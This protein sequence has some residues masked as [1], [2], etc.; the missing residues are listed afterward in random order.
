MTQ[1]DWSKLFMPLNFTDIKKTLLHKLGIAQ[2][3]VRV[4][5]SLNL[6]FIPVKNINQVIFFF[7]VCR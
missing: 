3:T 6:V 7:F 2:R 5:F 4:Y 1:D